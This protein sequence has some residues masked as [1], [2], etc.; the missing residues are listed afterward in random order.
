MK[1]P[2]FACIIVAAVLFALSGFSR[3]FGD[4][5]RPYYPSLVSAGLFFYMLSLIMGRG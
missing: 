3:W 2:N 4:P 5:Q 1:D